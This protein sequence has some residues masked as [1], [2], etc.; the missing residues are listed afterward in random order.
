M[1]VA[2]LFVLAF[3]LYV[4]YRSSETVIN[5]A[6]DLSRFFN[7]SQVAIGFV[8][9]AFA[10]SLPEL[11]VSVISSSAG[12]GALSAGNVFGSNITNILV[13]LG[14]GAYFYGLKISHSNLKEIGLVLLLTTLI[15]IYII[16]NS[17]VQN[18]ALTFFEGLALLS[19][20]GIY[21]YYVLKQKR[22][23]K[24]ENCNMTK[25][26]ALEAFLA[27]CIGILLLVVSS[28]FVV[29]SAVKIAVS[30]GIAESFIGATV[31]ALGTSLPELSVA[32][33][34]LRKKQ[35]GLV[36]GNVIGSN[37]ANLTFVLGVAAIIN[38]IEV[39]LLVFLAA[40]LF[41]VVA[42]SLL[43]YVAAI[44]KGIG[45]LG[46]ALF[47]LIFVLYLVVIFGLQASESGIISGGV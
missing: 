32:L 45:R 7:V 1:V 31:I 23:S 21:I 37:M 35:Y 43:F 17:T 6:V 14:I 8:L 15:S 4:L 5:S 13:I 27:F 38:P 19:I 9:V 18:K 28:S 12:E 20:F 10:T 41:A 2:E 33:V 16:Y 11:S 22:F 34:S 24:C 40:L 44:N 47:L 30:L 3:S 42:N 39:K 46:G 29:D 25:R 26:Q 36:L